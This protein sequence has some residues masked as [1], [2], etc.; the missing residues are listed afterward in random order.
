MGQG[1][2][3]E[4]YATS[5]AAESGHKR[6]GG[7]RVKGLVL[8]HTAKVAEVILSGLVLLVL[9]NPLVEVSL[10]EVNLLG[11]LEETRP[12]MSIKLLLAELHLDI[13]GRVVDLA[14][15]RVNLGVE[16]KLDMVGLL[17]GVGVAGEDETS[18]LK[19]E[20]EVGSRDVGNADGE[21]DEV[22]L[23]VGSRRALGPAN[24]RIGIHCQQLAY[25][26]CDRNHSSW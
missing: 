14:R 15:S 18:G 20:L 17:E 5:G 21:V 11:L 23:G 9:I 1:L 24:C 12:V 16:L 8:T 26:Q 2:W 3:L 25:I 13:T 10:E 4:R 7:T 19:V 22:V 6:G